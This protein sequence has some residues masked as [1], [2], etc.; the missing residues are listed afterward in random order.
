[1]PRP[2]FELSFDFGLD[3][4]VRFNQSVM[5][6]DPRY[7]G[8]R[9]VV[10]LMAAASLVGV[11]VLRAWAYAPVVVALAL[12]TVL[13]SARGT[14][15]V[16]RLYLGRALRRGVRVG[17]LGAWRVTLD[18]DGL[19]AVTAG[20]RSEVPWSGVAA[21]REAR[22]GLYLMTG[23]RTGYALPRRA[24]TD[25]EGLAAY[26]VA[27]VRAAHGGQL[28]VARSSYR[29][30]IGLWAFLLVLLWMLYTLPGRRPAG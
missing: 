6:S 26:A 19:T 22:D 16:A 30:T 18:D 25:P 29:S 2:A 14:A 28:P 13:L 15:L 10:P 17:E 21:V 27:R 23:P 24:A 1:M 5:A 11:V 9:R 4:L 3:D 8:T 7:R 20:S 12:M